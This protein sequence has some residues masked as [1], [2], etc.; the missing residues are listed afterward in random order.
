MRQRLL[1]CALKRQIEPVH[2]AEELD[3]FCL[4]DSRSIIFGNANIVY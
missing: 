4:P 1:R 3:Q 2:W